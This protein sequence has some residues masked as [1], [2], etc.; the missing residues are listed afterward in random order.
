MRALCVTV[1]LDRDVNIRIPGSRAA[2]SI[3]RG[4]GAGPRFSSSDK[5]LSL[6]ADL[7]DEI[8]IKATFFAEAAT[9]R[10]VDAGL[11]SGHEVGIHGVEHEDLAS[12][13]G[14]D[15]KR[16]ILKEASEAVKD[17]VGREPSC[18]RAPYMG[19]DRETIGMLPEFGI[20]IDSSL[21]RPMS[22][23]LMPEK[24]DCGVWEMPV[25]EGRDAAGKKISAY[26]WPMHESKRAPEDYIR[27]ASSMEEGAF[28]LATHTWHIVES[29]ERGIMSVKE[30]EQNIGNVRKV[31]EGIEDLGI[32][33]MTL[34]DV[35]KTMEG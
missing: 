4:I 3:D 16:A 24:M 13:E 2:G 20:G 9:L 21:Y 17:A 15:E 10:R 18:F 8:A 14:T 33:P 1:D 19:A 5:G 6:L 7:F 22:P 12:I 34:T 31:L 23:S 29:R 26:L 27:M 25:P 11:L 32:R 30:I 28:V 35:R